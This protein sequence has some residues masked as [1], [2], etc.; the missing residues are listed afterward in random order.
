MS[1]DIIYGRLIHIITHSERVRRRKRES[2]R[3]REFPVQSD[4]MKRPVLLA[5]K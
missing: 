3:E 5:L 2:E 4:I 1:V